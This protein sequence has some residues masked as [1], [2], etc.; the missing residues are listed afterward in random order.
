M[1]KLTY[2]PSREG[3]LSEGNKECEILFIFKEPNVD[4][5]IK[6]D[7]FW[8]RDQVMPVKGKGV[9]H[10]ERYYEYL[11][12]M[13]KTFGV[14][15]EDCGYMNLY[16]CNG[17]ET[18]S[19]GYQDFLEE[20][21][22]RTESAKERMQSVEILKPKRIVSCRQVYNTLIKYYAPVDSADE[23]LKYQDEEEPFNSCKVNVSGKDIPAFA[24]YHPL[25][26]FDILS[27]KISLQP[28]PSN[29]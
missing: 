5:E 11:S 23:S 17:E 4:G 19:K 14:A 18:P 12:K 21:Q 6:D 9:K 10:G 28:A 22:K 2:D 15:L 27:D 1:N 20:M 3:L 26:P 25:Y 8:F 29:E 24:F 16:P 7:I 13:A